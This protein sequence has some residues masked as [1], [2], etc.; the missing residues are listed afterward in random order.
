M[1]GFLP[2]CGHYGKLSRRGTRPEGQLQAAP[3]HR[4]ALRAGLN[5]LR[6]FCRSFCYVM[7]TTMWNRQNLAV[8]GFMFICKQTCMLKSRLSPRLTGISVSIAQLTVGVFLLPL[9]DME[10]KRDRFTKFKRS[11]I[12]LEK[13]SRETQCCWSRSYGWR[14]RSRQSQNV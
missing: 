5:W 12:V 7:D 14:H 6:I 11:S 9:P 3:V 13:L 8:T 10:N 1:A 4:G 2:A